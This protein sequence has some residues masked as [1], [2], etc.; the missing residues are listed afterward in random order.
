MESVSAWEYVEENSATAT[1]N[2][3]LKRVI[4]KMK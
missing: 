1:P 4:I 2:Y 3:S